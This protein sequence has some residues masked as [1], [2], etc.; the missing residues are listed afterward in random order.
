VE[1]FKVS[2]RRFYSK[3][4]YSQA[5]ERSFQSRLLTC[6]ERTLLQTIKQGDLLF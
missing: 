3:G 6:I 2:T 5:R 1:N 4:V